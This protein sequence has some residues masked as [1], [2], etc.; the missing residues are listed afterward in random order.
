MASFNEV[1]NAAGLAARAG[2]ASPR[3]RHS[4]K[5]AFVGKGIGLR[6]CFFDMVQ[7]RAAGARR[8]ERP[9]RRRFLL[10]RRYATVEDPTT[11]LGGLVVA[12][13]LGAWC[14]DAGGRGE[15]AKPHLR[16]VAEAGAFL[17]K[18]K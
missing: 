9:R 11:A 14:D 1:P 7:P 4:I 6:T 18:R 12:A 15:H 10:E 8:A 3:A 17:L 16:L 13:D 2:A 5:G